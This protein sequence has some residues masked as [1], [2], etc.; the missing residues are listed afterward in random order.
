MNGSGGPVSYCYSRGLRQLRLAHVFLLLVVL[1]VRPAVAQ[2]DPVKNFC[3]RFGHQAAVVDRKI[4]IDGGLVNYNSITQYPGNYSNTGLLYHD[5][6][7]TGV[8]GMPQLFANLTKNS[9]VPSVHGG[10]LWAD[11]IN[12]RLY[13]FGGQYYQQP[14]SP[15]FTLWSYDILNNEWV[16]L[17]APSYID[18]VS[19]GAGVSVPERGEAYYYGG[20]ISNNSV[21]DWTGPPA[22]TSSLLKYNMDTN[23]WTNGTGPDTIRRAEGAMVF[24]PIGDGGM[25]VYFGGI[26]DKD[27]NGTFVGQPMNQ[28][29]VY[30]VLSSKWYQQKAT[31]RVPQNRARFCAGATWAQDQSSYNI[32]IYGG[33]GL[34]ADTSGFDDVY[35]LSIPAFQWIKLYPDKSNETGQYPHHSLTCNVID[36]AQ[37]MIIG[38]TFPL[39]QDCDVPDQFGSHNL[40]MGL[41]NS[42]LSPWK[43]YRSNLTS[44]AVPAP[45][46]SAIG[47]NSRGGASK[48]APTDGFQ[49]PDLKVLMTRKASIS[50]RTATR[51][52]TTSTSPADST[53]GKHLSTAAIAGISVGLVVA[54]LAALISC[55]CLFKRYRARRIFSPPTDDKRL[56]GDRPSYPPNTHH[57]VPPLLQFQ[58]PTELEAD[59][60]PT[61]GSHTWRSADGHTYELV[62][63]AT[64]TGPVTP[65]LRSG[66]AHPGSPI[67]I[68]TTAGLDSPT[69]PA[70]VLT[71][72][73]G[74]GTGT[75]G[76]WSPGSGT[77]S[78]ELQTKIDAE[79]RIWV[80]VPIPFRHPGTGTGT[81][82]VS[83]GT[84]SQSRGPVGYSPG[85]PV[86]SF[87]MSPSPGPGP[88]VAGRVEVP[89]EAEPQELPV[90]MPMPG[91]RVG[92]GN[93]ADWEVSSGT[94]AGSVAGTGT[95]MPKHETYYHP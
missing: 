89:T 31:G 21:L 5:L 81:G 67:P 2:P 13:L 3:R 79:G 26:Q 36:N 61:T 49:N 64:A 29:Y 84:Q 22:A 10:S 93:D 14:P 69:D 74:T 90:P 55:L 70:P 95:G 17:D 19:Y 1:S 41:Q 78:S 88:G 42:D 63:P 47:G 60:V 27:S 50:Q 91:A 25:L 44:Y 87:D 23:S 76:S 24:I 75:G 48:T 4:Y 77:G 30:D 16:A 37:M 12:K 40:D 59:A 28:I 53:G 92:K 15:Y 66:F 82:S 85:T 65:D 7:V 33:A 62:T 68:P 20:W 56:A 43:L 80:Q 72:I 73:Y 51:S 35:I 18:S 9:S 83:P 52:L 94:G 11:N 38:G 8:G 32:Y 54:F 71:P 57:G 86:S 39:T 58:P 46:L 6:N 45:L 34:G